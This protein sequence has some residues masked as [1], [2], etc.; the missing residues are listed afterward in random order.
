MDEIDKNIVQLLTSNARMTVKEIA[1]RVSLT[2]PAVSQRIHNMEESGIIAGYTVRLNPEL[3]RGPVGAVVSIYV[4]PKH[5]DDFHR[6]IALEDGVKQCHQITGSESHIM[7]VRCK[8]I[9]ELEKFI[10]R[11]QKMGQTSTQVI[12]ETVK[13]E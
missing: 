5:R 6:C 11:M 7:L 2:S 9:V 12:L 1:K 4:S 8:T 10:S 13:E 3:T